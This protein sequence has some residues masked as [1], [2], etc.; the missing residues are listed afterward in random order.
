M[1]RN[2][3]GLG[4]SGNSRGGAT[5]AQNNNNNDNNNEILIKREPLVYTRARRFVQKRKE[6]K[7]RTVQPQ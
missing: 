2:S 1:S 4:G 3:G 6:E 5:S 7:A